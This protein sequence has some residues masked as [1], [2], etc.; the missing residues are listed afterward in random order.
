MLEKFVDSLGKE[1]D[2]RELIKTTESGQYQLPFANDVLV[3]ALFS[4]EGTYQFKSSI[5]KNPELK[6]E[7]FYVKALEATLFGKGTRGAAIGLDEERKL[8]T[9]SLEV[10]YNSTY[11]DWK[12]KLEDFVNVLEY[13][14]N[15]LANYK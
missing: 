3:L 10:D 7:D 15:E 11:K 2:M 6:P 14:R 4:P 12:E 1:L 8:L 13:W 9:L 5:G